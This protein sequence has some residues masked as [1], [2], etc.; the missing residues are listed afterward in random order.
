MAFLKRWLQVFFFSGNS[1]PLGTLVIGLKA[2]PGAKRFVKFSKN[3]KDSTISNSINNPREIK[4]DRVPFLFRTRFLHTC[5]HVLRTCEVRCGRGSLASLL[6]CSLPFIFKYRI[7]LHSNFDMQVFAL[8]LYL[9]WFTLRNLLS[10]IYYLITFEPKFIKIV[11]FTWHIKV[12]AHK[13]VSS[14]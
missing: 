12:M 2:L 3:D 10:I 11:L 14:M 7:P 8:L 5:G 9:L 1:D 13:S 4:F 6:F